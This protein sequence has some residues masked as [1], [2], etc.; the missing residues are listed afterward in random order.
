MQLNDTKCV[1][2]ISIYVITIMAMYRP[3]DHQSKIIIVLMI[4]P[5]IAHIFFIPPEKNVKKT[6]PLCFFKLHGCKVTVCLHR[7]S[8]SIQSNVDCQLSVKEK[9]K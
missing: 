4:L 2:Y 7:A 6:M 1:G 3:I 9:T 8:W 5:V